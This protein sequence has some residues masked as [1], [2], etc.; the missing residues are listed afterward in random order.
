M[1]IFLPNFSVIHPYT[2]TNP[3]MPKADSDEIHDSSSVVIFP[4]L[5]G[6]SSDLNSSRFGPL[7]PIATPK[8]NAVMFT[9]QKRHEKL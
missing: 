3:I 8:M 2:N 6:V 9:V 4:E 7:K 5:K 1:E